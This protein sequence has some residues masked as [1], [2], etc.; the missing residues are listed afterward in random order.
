MLSF[1]AIGNK[2]LVSWFDGL[3][4]MISYI[5]SMFLISLEKYVKKPCLVLKNKPFLC[6]TSEASS[7]LNF[8]KN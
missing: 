5:P 8:S 6:D 3:S 1:F 4:V 2:K 7:T